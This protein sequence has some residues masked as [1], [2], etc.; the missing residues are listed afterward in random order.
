MDHF[1]DGARLPSPT[2]GVDALQVIEEA[3]SFHL[4]PKTREAMGNQ[5]VQ[6]AKA[7]KY[8]SAGTAPYAGAPPV[9]EEG[10]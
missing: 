6:L 9:A 8:Y 3:P 1:A 4:D 2:G 7:V 10:R 5:A